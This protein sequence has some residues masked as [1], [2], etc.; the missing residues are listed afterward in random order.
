MR[1]NWAIQEYRRKKTDTAKREQIW[2]IVFAN[3]PI[4]KICEFA[5]FAKSPY[6]F[7]Q[8]RED[9]ALVAVVVADADVLGDV[10]VARQRIRRAHL[11]CVFEP[12]FAKSPQILPNAAKLSTPPECAA[13]RS[14]IRLCPIL[15]HSADFWNRC[16]PFSAVS[17]P[18]FASKYAFCSIFQ[19]LQ[20]YRYTILDSCC[21]FKSLHRFHNFCCILTN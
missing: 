19:N 7:R 18:I 21:F 2:Q 5:K 3:S 13:V 4:C 1:N 6:N 20:D 9:P 14:E 11:T 10:L 17:K 8:K 16:G 12:T 15:I